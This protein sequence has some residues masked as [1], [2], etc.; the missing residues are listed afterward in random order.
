LLYRRW[1]DRSEL[2]PHANVIGEVNGAYKKSSGDTSGGDYVSGEL[3]VSLG[4]DPALRQRRRH[5]CIIP[6]N[7]HFW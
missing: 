7:G 6:V 4:S 1:F 2:V 5:D 3:D